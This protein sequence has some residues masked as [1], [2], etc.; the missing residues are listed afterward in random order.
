MSTRILIAD[1]HSIL[2]QGLRL[3]IDGQKDMELVAEATNGREA[4]DMA[5]EFQPDLIIMDIAMPDVNGIEATR[6]IKKRHPNVKILALSMHCEKEFV[7][8]ILEAGASGYLT[9][10]SVFDEIKDAITKVMSE[11][12]YICSKVSQMVH[13]SYV[14]S[15]RDQSSNQENLSPRELEVL[16]MLAD[17]KRTKDIAAEL[18][19][20]PPTVNVY[21]AKIYKKLSINSVV[22]LTKYA[23]RNN[24]I[25]I[26]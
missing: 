22:E 17:G 9:K 5:D 6:E 11:G 4:I 7:K 18:F 1:D 25:E 20:S 2:R 19:I 3:M 15:L 14:N 13:D 8:N 16:K 10:T 21:R 23:I 12:V 24:L 26:K